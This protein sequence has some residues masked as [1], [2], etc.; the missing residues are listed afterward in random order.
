MIVLSRCPVRV[1]AFL[2]IS[3]WLWLRVSGFRKQE[4]LRKK[5]SAKSISL[6]MR[7]ENY[8]GM[9]KQT[10]TTLIT[11]YLLIVLAAKYAKT[12]VLNAKLKQSQWYITYPFM[13]LFNSVG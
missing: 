7:Q 8:Y 13:R 3:S 11:T 6:L 12:G 1:A 5:K 9:G 2:L 4:D 10:K